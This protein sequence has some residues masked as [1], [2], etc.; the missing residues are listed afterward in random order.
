M[1]SDAVFDVPNETCRKI[2]GNNP[3]LSRLYADYTALVYF[4]VEIDRLD[5]YDLTPT[6]QFS[7]IM[8]GR[9]EIKEI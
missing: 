5:Y 7:G 1:S 8:T 3:V 6:P 2:Y 4:R 9:R